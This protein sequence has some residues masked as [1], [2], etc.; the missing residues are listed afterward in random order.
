MIGKYFIKSMLKN[1]NLWGWGVLF[2]LFW[3]FMGAFVFTSG[4]P[5]QEVYYKL[6][7]A[8]WFG[9][10]GLISASTLA[11]SISQSIYYGNSSLA[12]AFRFTTLKPSG[13]ISSFMLSAA[14]IGGV[15]SGIMLT[16]TYAIFSYNTGYMLIPK[17]PYVSVITGF[18]AGAFMF[19][20]ASIIIIVF[21]NYLGLRNVTFASFIPMILTYLFGFTQF[22]TVLPAYI[23]YGSPFTDI[24]DILVWSYY[25][26]RVP[27]NT[28]E[29]IGTGGYINPEIQAMIL[30]IWILILAFSSF[31]LI[32]KIKPRSIEE[33]RQV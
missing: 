30:V 9:L 22:N 27:L 18:A 8:I 6:N 1:R 25:G 17:F 13:Y 19:L 31:L 5:K 4:F 10:I 23:I 7:A 2:M 28:L 3:L 24:S 33:G 29:P 11:T 15:F 14:I 16:V 26:H 21:N 12:Y 20:L 32:K